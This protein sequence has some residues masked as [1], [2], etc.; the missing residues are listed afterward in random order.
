M[1]DEEKREILRNG[2]GC[3]IDINTGIAV[4]EG[5]WERGELTE[6]VELFDGWYVKREGNDHL[7][8]D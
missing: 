5:V 7:I 4:R 2:Y 6:S 1:F 3:R 8:G